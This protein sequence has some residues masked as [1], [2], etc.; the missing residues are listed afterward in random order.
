MVTLRLDAE[1]YQSS[2]ATAS[3]DGVGDLDATVTIPAGAPTTGDAEISAEGLGAG[4]EVRQLAAG[5]RLSTS[6]VSDADGDGIPDPCD[7]CPGLSTSNAI[8]SDGDGAGDA[9]DPCPNDFENDV[10]ADGLCAGA[11]PCPWDAENDA[12]FDGICESDDNC[13]LTFNPSQLDSD[14]DD[15]GNACDGAPFDPGVWAFP[16]E[17]AN[18]GFGGDK[19][20]LTWRSGSAAAG[21][22][23]RHDVVRG[24]LV[25]LPFEM[26]GP[27][28][29][30]ATLES[31]TT[32]TGTPALGEAFWYL[33]RAR[34]TLGV[35]TYGY[36]SSGSERN[37]LASCP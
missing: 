23:T 11:D 34:N 6:F 15:V 1:T 2:F 4:G 9:C 13:P 33:A 27:C 21:P 14:G 20:T 10:D 12:E 32:D 35:G 37:V 24:A 29:V 26:Y 5:I 18:L 17:V 30:S 31:T 36:A 8:D 3:A 16:G 7:N 25:D 28:I 19:V 22:L